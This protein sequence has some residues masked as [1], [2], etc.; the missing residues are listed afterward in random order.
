MSA[1]KGL[2]EE[3]MPMRRQRVTH[4]LW[5]LIGSLGLSLGLSCDAADEKG[6]MDA[7]FG[8]TSLV[9]KEHDALTVGLYSTK[10]DVID[11]MTDATLRSGVPLSIKLTG[12]VFVNQSSA[13]S[14]Y[15]GSDANHCRV[16]QRR[17]HARADAPRNS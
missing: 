6:C 7:R 15:H 2:Q 1:G 17:Y 11:A 16:I 4:L 5:A 12:G 14:D 8:P 9:F 10:Q 3:G 13:D